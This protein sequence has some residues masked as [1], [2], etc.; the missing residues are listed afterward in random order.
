MR[1]C[2][3]LGSD[4]ILNRKAEREG[5]C[6]ADWGMVNLGM[7][8]VDVTNTVF[9]APHEL[10]DGKDRKAPNPTF[11]LRCNPKEVTPSD[12]IPRR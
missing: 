7:A 2:I 3:S 1:T 6:R 9:L 5:G 8:D 10:D 11:L 12:S 4:S